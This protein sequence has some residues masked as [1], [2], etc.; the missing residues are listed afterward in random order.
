[1]LI[2]YTT[3]RLVLSILQPSQADTVLSFYEKNRTFLEKHEPL[4]PANFYTYNYQKTNLSCEYNAFFKCSY[5][6]YWIFLKEDTSSPIGTI[7]FSNFKKG[8]FCSCMVGYKLDEDFCNKG[9]M[10]ESLSF[11]IPLVCKDCKMHRVEAMVMPDNNP[12]IRLLERLN[13]NK[14]G[15]LKDFAQING[16][17]EDHYL[18]TYINEM[19]PL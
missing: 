7:C 6:R 9:Y 17:W 8:A 15:H 13:F 16:K 18:Y 4:R 2:S 11:L 14:E 1:M 10:Y 12:S 3:N 5:L 19:N